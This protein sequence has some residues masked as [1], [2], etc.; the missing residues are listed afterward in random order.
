MSEMSKEERLI[1]ALSR[2]E[3]DRVPLYDLVDNVAVIEHYSGQRLTQE[4]AE[5]VIPLALSRAVDH[6]RVWMPGE[7]GIRTDERGFGY[8]RRTWFNEWQVSKP[9]SDLDGLVAF[10]EADIERLDASKPSDPDAHFRELQLWKERFAPTT[11]PAAQAAEALTDA[12]I[13]VGVDWFVW[14]N[15]DHP[16]LVDRWVNAHHT[17]SLRRLA[18][19]A[20]C[21]AISP[22]GWIFA[23]M[24][25]KG[26]L[27]FSPHFLRSRG[28]FRRIADFCDVFHGYGLKVIFHS[29]GYLRP[30]VPELI[31]AGVDAIAPV[32]T[33]S[34]PG[35]DLASLK[36]A[37]GKQ[38]AFCGGLDVQEVLQAGTTD[39]VRRATLQALAAAGPGGGLILGSS[40]EE[41][42]NNL[43]VE[44]IIAMWETT[45]ECGRYPIGKYF[46]AGFGGF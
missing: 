5:Q 39:D 2:E 1:C 25:F 15:T 21:R 35:M 3:P 32:E 6:T 19:R 20:G 27:M 18:A 22:V 7:I 46:P 11:I 16:A 33:G 44:N 30:V 42:F 14:L 36:A 10:V 13:M 37:F 12:Y 24:A 29:D 26:R 28:V 41:L 17:A 31:A 45:H 9:F 23:D 38:V 40:S 43:P 34:G 4:S 8:E